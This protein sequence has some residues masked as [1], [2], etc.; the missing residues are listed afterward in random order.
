MRVLCAF[1]LLS[2]AAVCA[3]APKAKRRFLQVVEGETTDQTVLSIIDNGYDTPQLKALWRSYDIASYLKPGEVYTVFAPT[4]DAVTQVDPALFERIATDDALATAVLQYHVVRGALGT[5]ELAAQSDSE[6]ETLEGSMLPILADGDNIT[7]GGIPV[8]LDSEQQGTDGYVHLLQRVLV[9]PS[10]MEEA[11]VTPAPSEE[12]RNASSPYPDCPVEC[13]DDWI[14]DRWCDGPCA[15]EA[16]GNDGG[17]CEGWC[18]PGCSP[19]DIHGRAA[20][21][22][23]GRCDEACNVEESICSPM[24]AF[25]YIACDCPQE[26]LGNWECDTECNTEACNRDGGDCKGECSTSCYDSSLGDGICEIACLNEFC[27]F[28]CGD[29][30]NCAEGCTIEMLLNDVCDAPCAVDACAMDGGNC[31]TPVCWRDELDEYMV[32]TKTE[33]GDGYCNEYCHREE[34]NFD[35]GDCDRPDMPDCPLDCAMGWPG[36]DICDDVCNIKECNFDNGDCEGATT[37]PPE[38]STPPP[39]ESGSVPSGACAAV[40]CFEE[41]LGDGECDEVCNVEQCGFDEGDC[42]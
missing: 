21:I 15:V 23:D 7:V 31:E 40:Y 35:G 37:P 17:D 10:V 22:N 18:A 33:I 42:Q 12:T 6:L 20:M 38:D 30:H 5:Q 3:S 4:D 14:G 9:P 13:P 2:A 32:C 16:C 41:W 26:K 1:F 28:D 27:G 29:C 24:S 25:N 34:C 19:K 39:E 8:V 36:D 11:D